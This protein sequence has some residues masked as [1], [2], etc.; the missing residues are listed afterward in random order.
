MRSTAGVDLQEAVAVLHLHGGATKQMGKPKKRHT[1]Y[2]N[3]RK[4]K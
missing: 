3:E 1:Y 2:N 4:L